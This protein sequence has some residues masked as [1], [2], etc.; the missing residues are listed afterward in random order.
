MDK[1]K[2]LVLV[3]VFFV[4]SIISVKSQT[5]SVDKI[6]ATI[7]EFVTLRNNLSTTAEGGAA[8]FLLA[9]KIY[10]DNP[11]FGLQCLVVS[12]DKNTLREGDTYNGFALFKQDEDLIKKQ[13]AH[14]KNIPNSYI[15]GSSPDNGYEVKLPYEYEFSGNAYSGDKN[16]GTYKVF[17]ACSGAD[18]KRPFTMKRNDKGLWKATMWSSVVVGIKKSKSE[19]SDDL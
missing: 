18:S 3:F 19:N 14:N 15:K 10:V 13:L 7:E 11:E 1:M 4:F 6:P 9:L 16:E 12:V 8:V 17:V 2:N 5:I